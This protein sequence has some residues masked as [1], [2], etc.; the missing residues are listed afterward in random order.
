[1]AAPKGNKYATKTKGVSR[2]AKPPEE[3]KVLADSLV[4]WSYEDED[5]CH[6]AQWTT[7]WNKTRQWLYSLAENHPE[8]KE[9]LNTARENLATR[10]ALF[11]LKGKW[12]AHLVSL[13]MGQ[14]DKEYRQYQREEKAADKAQQEKEK[15]DL[16]VKVTKHVIEETKS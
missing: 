2:N 12:Q 5:A 6:L 15:Q 10:Y 9:A 1:M 13:K 4:K 14:Y 11:G 3:I 7:Q 8:L 16:L